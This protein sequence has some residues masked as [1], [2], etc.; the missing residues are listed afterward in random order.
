MSGHS[1]F[2]CLF[3][4]HAFRTL[5]SLYIGTFFQAGYA[6]FNLIGTLFYGSPWLYAATFYSVVLVFARIY[7]I[8]T[9]RHTDKRNCSEAKRFKRSAGL[10]MILLAFGL[11]FMISLP[12]Y[13]SKR[14]GYNVLFTLVY[15]IYAVLSVLFSAIGIIRLRHVGTPVLSAAK[16]ISF[17]GASASVLN[18]QNSL[19]PVFQKNGQFYRFCHVALGSSAVLLL[20]VFG[21]F[22][23]RKKHV[24]KNYFS[25]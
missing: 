2:A 1:F 3:H 20:G 9:Y 18:L 22:F 17:A 21:I 5:V 16:V 15:A 23:L 12:F 11:L 8:Y 4:S 25:E 13:R 10:F 14:E 6:I 24:Y 19:L 7:L